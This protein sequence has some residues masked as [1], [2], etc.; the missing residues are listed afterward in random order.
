M[1]TQVLPPQ[2]PLG[3]RPFSWPLAALL[4]LC[5]LFFSTGRAF[6]ASPTVR[7]AYLQNDIHHLA[8][9]V[10]LDQ[11]YFRQYGLEAKVAGIFRSGPELMAAFGAGELDAAYA[12]VAP[13]TIAAVR[14][15]AKVR[16]LAQANTEGSA[17]VG[18]ER[19][20]AGSRKKPT[21]AMP[22]NGG[23][24]DLLLRK[25]L[26][27][28]GI[29]PETVDIIVLSP[30]EMLTALQIGEIDGFLAWE[31]YPSRAVVLGLGT[32]LS[33]SAGIWA[34]HP[35]CALVASD[36]LIRERPEQA[37]ALL[38]IHRRATR[39]I[40]ENPDAAVAVAVRYT[41][42]EEAIVR[43]ALGN[44]SYT[45]IP[46]IAGVEEYVNFLQRLRYI[47]VNDAKAFI[48]QFI[49][50]EFRQTVVEQP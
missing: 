32:V 46:N 31:P 15:T 35:C 17:L 50:E 33:S 11:D 1:A 16:V 42:M 22:G 7:L 29:S 19:V 6:G 39:F 20:L 27:A 45:E 21:L 49:A 30:P 28:L 8:L 36:A 13:A 26:P 40:H 3:S 18:T 43:R 12:G 47:T 38:R 9:W 41:G 24:Q 5:I 44:V 23:V 34:D 48:R 25:A 4:C 14:G 37:K 10:A 2:S